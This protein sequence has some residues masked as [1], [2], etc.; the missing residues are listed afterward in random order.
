MFADR[1]CRILCQL[2]FHVDRLSYYKD[3]YHKLCENVHFDGYKQIC[4]E[5]RPFLNINIKL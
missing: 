1:R 4:L 3:I 5:I 2:L